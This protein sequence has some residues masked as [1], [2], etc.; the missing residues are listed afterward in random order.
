MRKFI[1][2]LVAVIVVG[3]TPMAVVTAATPAVSSAQCAY[4]YWWDPAANV[5]RPQQGYYGPQ[6]GYYGPQQGYWGPQQGYGGW[7]S[8]CITAPI[9]FVPMTWCWPIG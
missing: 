8:M 2:R 7:G 9:P 4:G 5:C 1:H 3:L 6:Q